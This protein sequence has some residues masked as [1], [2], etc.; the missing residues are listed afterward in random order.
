MHHTGSTRTPRFPTC[1]GIDKSGISAHRTCVSPSSWFVCCRLGSF[2]Q[3]RQAW[4]GS[5]ALLCLLFLLD[6]PHF[7]FEAMTNLAPWSALCHSTQ[8]CNE[9]GKCSIF[10]RFWEPP[11]SS[12]WPF[13]VFFTCFSPAFKP[14]PHSA[15][16][17]VGRGEESSGA[18]VWS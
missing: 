8:F 2:L 12:R 4:Q 18:M 7:S 9:T 5:P 17:V 14:T 16:S 6:F 13:H 1:L 3:P 11:V 10:V 15:H